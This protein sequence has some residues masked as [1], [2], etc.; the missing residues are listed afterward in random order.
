MP[1]SYYLP[2][3]SCFP[4][5]FVLIWE[6][7]TSKE[8]KSLINCVIGLCSLKWFLNFSTE[9][10]IMDMENRLVVAKGEGKGMG[11]IGNLVLIDRCKRLPLE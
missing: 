8:L 10:E 5:I 1:L 9:K 2:F 4:N 3:R 6:V 7:R 11:W